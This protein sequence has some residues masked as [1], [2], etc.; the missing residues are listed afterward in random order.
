MLFTVTLLPSAIFGAKVQNYRLPNGLQIL[1]LEDHRAPVVLTSVWYK[2][3][4]SYER[5]GI[6]GISHVLEHMMFK[7]TTANGPGEFNQK[8]ADVGGEQ[9][10]MTGADYTVYY[11]KLPANQ[12]EL[13]FALEADRMH[14][15]LLNADAFKKEIQVVK[16]ERRMRVDDNPQGTMWERF[17][18]A[19]FLNNPYHH[20]VVGWMNDLENLTIDDVK[21]WYH[22]WYGP[23]NAILVVVGDVKFDRV[24]NLAQKY[25]GPLKA[26]HSPTLKPRKEVRST[27]VKTV[28]VNVPAN[29]AWLMMGYQVPTLTTIAGQD[30]KNIYALK[31]VQLIL[32]Q[33]ESARLE[34]FL[35]RKDH[36]AVSVSANYDP[37]DLHDTLFSF[38][39]VPAPKHTLSELKKAV[40]KQIT[41]LKRKRVSKDELEKVKAQLLAHEVF[42]KDSLM[43]MAFRMGNPEVVGLSW[44]SRENMVKNISAITPKEIQQVANLYLTKNKLTIAELNPS[45]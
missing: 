29:T 12:L 6:T 19:A 44:R 7:G 33:G 26:I 10:A 20:P 40:Y 45:K 4:G 41:I 35:V 24:Y 30:K 18:A 39:G 3:G 37:Y 34:K 22:D 25:F 21:K 42:E 8:I 13:S 28:T 27:G 36:V 1:V 16:E 38:V 2:V 32:S 31:L 17:K 11:Q 43:H 9:N 23:N 5:N 15:L 14:N